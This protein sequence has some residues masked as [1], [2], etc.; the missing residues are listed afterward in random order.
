MDRMRNGAANQMLPVELPVALR[1]WIKDRVEPV[2]SEGTIVF[3]IR[4][5]GVTEQRLKKNTGIKGAFTKDLDAKYHSEILVDVERINSG[6]IKEPR[7]DA[8]ASLTRS[9]YEDTPAHERKQFLYDLM[10]DSMTMFDRNMDAQLRQWFG[11]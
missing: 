4:K 6:A 2:G 3:H 1:Q 7:G 11:F 10:L 5:A 9:V 8:S